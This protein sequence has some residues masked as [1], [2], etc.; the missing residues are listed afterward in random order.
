MA[1]LHQSRRPDRPRPRPDK[2]AVDRSRRRGGAARVHL[3]AARRHGERRRAGADQARPRAR[4]PGR[5]PVRQPR[6][7]SRR[8]LRH[9]ARGLRRG[10]GELQVPAPD[11][12]FHH[13]GFR[14]ASSCSATRRGAR[15]ARTSC[16]SS[17]SAARA[18]KASMPSS[19][20]ARSRRSC[21]RRASR[22]CSST[23]PARPARPRASS[24][25]T[26]ATSGWWRRGSRPGSTAIAI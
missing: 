6:R 20:R 22:R 2:V 12:P 7:I 14:R 3:C 4:R 18:P 11:H 10:A 25:R 26:R 15:I 5:D 21:R 1:T 13:Q 24:S 17:T 16:R 19:T 23:P 8:L 9:H